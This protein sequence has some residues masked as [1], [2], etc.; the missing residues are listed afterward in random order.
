MAGAQTPLMKQYLEIK[1]NYQD[2]ILFFRLGDFYEMFFDDAQKAAPIL[3]IALTCRDKNA[4]D[5]VPLCG[6]PHHSANSYIAKLLDHGLNV[7]ICE[8]MEEAAASKGLVKRDVVKVVTPSMRTE[9]EGLSSTQDSYIVSIY[10]STQNKKILYALAWMNIANG[11]F[12]STV[13]DSLSNLEHQL[14]QLKAKEILVP[15][16]NVPAELSAWQTAFASV[17]RDVIFHALDTWV[18]SEGE[19]ALADFFNLNN[20]HGLGFSNIQAQAASCHAIIYYAKDLRKNNCNHLDIPKHQHSHQFLHL[21]KISQNHLDLFPNAHSSQHDLF[22]LLNH[23]KNT[24]GTRLLYTWMSQ[25]LLDQEKINARLSA[26]SSL[27]EQPKTLEQ[28]Q[29]LLKGI[30]DLERLSSKIIQ[31][32]IK[33]LELLAILQSL[34]T[35]PLIS[36]HL[37][38]LCFDANNALSTLSKNL[39]SCKPIM[40]LLQQRLQDEPAKSI[41]DAW[42]IKDGFNSQL[43]EL[44]KLCTHGQDWLSQLEQQEKKNTGITTLKVR[45]NKVFGYYIEVSKSHINKVPA[46]YVRKQTLV[47]AERFITEELKNYEV[48]LL[49]AQDERL[50]LEKE[51][52]TQ[53]LVELAPLAHELK[54]QAHLIAQ[55]DVLAAFAQAALQ[56]NYI[57]PNLCAKGLTLKIKQGRH[58]MLEQ[59]LPNNASFVP[60]DLTLDHDQQ[61][62][63]ILTGP[64]MSGKS[65]LM[66]QTALIVYMAHIG[67]FVPAQEADIPYVDQIFTRVGTGDDLAQGRSTFMVEMNETAKILR[68]ASQNSLIILDEVGRGTSTYDGLALAWAVS[69][70]LHDHIAA[71]TLFAT[72]YHELT[73]LAEQK[74]KMQNYHVAAKLWQDSIVFLHSLKQGPASQSYGLEVAKMAGVLDD[75]VHRAR[76]VLNNLEQQHMKP[77][78]CS[79]DFSATSRSKAQTSSIVEQALKDTDLNSLSPKQA[80]DLLYQ[81]QNEIS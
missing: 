32:T 72:H 48:K 2:C 27:Y 78:Q 9:T 16:K 7:A 22:S 65:T 17:Q 23:C 18:F 76:Q 46:H 33:P 64:N 1:S 38:T 36:E 58:P 49:N 59:H 57:R 81:W 71:K 47:N 67:C 24:M 40:K 45:Y 68:N 79:F 6:V 63:I 15:N 50:R 31:H 69:E 26:V 42:V 19:K 66:R 25:A 60:N 43:D 4:K 10:P 35:I 30:C 52:Y 29:K 80:L 75:V 14:W 73:E 12:A 70:Y 3:D 77:P 61:Q 5:P 62:M 37:N 44:R 51:L 11:H 39:S 54:Q 20:L 34:Q 8:Q 28:L 41:E 53:L 56:N 21:D 13:L 55:I 74:P